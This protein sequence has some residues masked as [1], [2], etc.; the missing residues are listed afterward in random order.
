MILYFD[1]E[2]TGLR[3][4]N[5]CQLSYVMQ[6]KEKVTPKN[7]FF[8]VDFVEAGA[9][10]VH[11]FSVDFLRNASN[12]KR[13]FDYLEEIKSDFEN[14]DLVVSHNTAF[15]FM[16]LG[17]EFA[18]LDEALYIKDHLCS[19][20]KSTPLLALRRSNSAGYKYPKLSELCQYFDIS[21]DA[22]SKKVKEFYGENTSF[23]DARFDTVAVYLCLNESY[24][25]HGDYFS[26][27][28]YL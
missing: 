3:P 22:V 18:R 16:F 25:Y 28:E 8:T 1:T 9:Q 11:G 4:G 2:T 15:D 13:F 27:G 21:D 20:K 5:I 12:G 10:A 19:M 23:H 7:F 6:D 17:E 14:A 26:I 24:A